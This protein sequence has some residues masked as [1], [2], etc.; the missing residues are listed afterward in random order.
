M[1][2]KKVSKRKISN[3]KKVQ[4][5][6]A[7][8][9]PVAKRIIA[10]VAFLIIAGFILLCYFRPD[11]FNKI[12]NLFKPKEENFVTEVIGDDVYVKKLKDV[13]IHFVDV[14]QGDSIVIKLPDDTTMLI[15]AYN[16]SDLLD[17][18]KNTLKLTTIDYV[19]ATHSDADHI[20]AMDK[21]FENFEV[22]KVF[23]PYIK[24][25]GENTFTNDFNKGSKE[26]NSNAY[27]TFLT[28]L[29]NETYLDGKETKNC[30]WEFFNYNSDFSKNI[31]YNNQVY[32][33]TFD[34]LTP[35]VSVSDIGYSDVNSYSPIIKFSYCDT[36]I[37]FTGDAENE[38]LDEFLSK[39]TSSSDLEYLDVDVLKLGHHGSKTSTTK[40]FLNVVKPEYAIA[41]CGEGNSYGHP[42]Q[43]VLDLLLNDDI[44]LYRTDLNGNIVLNIST[45]DFT[46]N[47]ENSNYFPNMYEAP[48]RD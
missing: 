20:G 33:F 42:H 2:K 12:L 18:L 24:H 9:S 23:R 30:E 28:H 38:S 31:H 8:L 16:D 27:A 46:F 4:K 5:A 37:L 21:V 41:S 22:K 11:V 45:T 44:L 3:S 10:I 6:V 13:E 40:P 36:D 43:E 34:F 19:L 7:G 15:D 26:A 39:Y 29:S 1:A 14:G 35:T 17:Y 47:L 48:P 25:G 32:T